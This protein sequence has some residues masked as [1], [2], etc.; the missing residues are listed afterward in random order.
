MSVSGSCPLLNSQCTSSTFYYFDTKVRT[1]PHKIKTTWYGC[2]VV[3]TNP[4]TAIMSFTSSSLL[5][6]HVTGFAKTTWQHH[7]SNSLY[8]IIIIF[9]LNHHIKAQ[10]HWGYDRLPTTNDQNGRRPPK[11]IGDRG[12]QKNVAVTL[13]T[14]LGLVVLPVGHNRSAKSLRLS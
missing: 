12:H 11:T 1:Q 9:F 2:T 8:F 7:A 10:S 14:S 4:I 5:I 3:N 13:A 6:S